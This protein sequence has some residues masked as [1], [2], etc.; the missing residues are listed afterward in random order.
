MDKT[1]V[2]KNVTF[3]LRGHCNHYARLKR[4]S[5]TARSNLREIAKTSVFVPVISC[6]PLYP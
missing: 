2:V 6:V 4:I 5:N 3:G 1:T